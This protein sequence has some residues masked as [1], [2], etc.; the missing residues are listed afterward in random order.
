MNKILDDEV[1]FS[2]NYFNKIHNRINQKNYADNKNIISP[3]KIKVE[4]FTKDLASEVLN[5]IKS[6]N[7]IVLED[8][9]QKNFNLLCKWIKDHMGNVVEYSGK[10]IAEVSYIEYVE[11]GKHYVDSCYTQPLHVDGI[12]LKKPPEYLMTYCFQHAAVGGETIL[13]EVS[14]LYQAL[15]EEFNEKVQLLFKSNITYLITNYNSFYQSVLFRDK[16]G[17]IGIYYAGMSKGLK[18]NKDVAEMYDFI[19]NYVH[20]PKYQKHYLLKQREALFISNTR[21]LHSRLRFRPD[22]KRKLARIWFN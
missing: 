14:D 21:L 12:W 16:N 11:G 6:N 5:C 17:E 22:S 10:D 4:K 1:T 15:K 18:C 9:H 20:S 7:F 3:K 19:S 8:I 2:I 13:V